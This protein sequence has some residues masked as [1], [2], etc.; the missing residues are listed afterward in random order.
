M[1]LVILITYTLRYDNVF[2]RSLYVS[3]FSKE[4][5]ETIGFRKKKNKNCISLSSCTKHLAHLWISCL[6]EIRWKNI[7]DNS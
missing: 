4:L 7:L 2:K 5:W 1:K 6:F 3:L